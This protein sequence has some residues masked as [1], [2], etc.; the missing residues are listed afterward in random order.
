MAILRNPKIMVAK[1][2]S[3]LYFDYAGSVKKY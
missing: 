2:L 3:I 1:P